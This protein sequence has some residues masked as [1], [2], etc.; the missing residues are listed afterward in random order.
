MYWPKVSDI[1]D[2]HMLGLIRNVF[3][4]NSRARLFYS[5]QIQL[6]L[7]ELKELA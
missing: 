6:K 1:V 4:N 7:M 3:A 5:Y 2:N